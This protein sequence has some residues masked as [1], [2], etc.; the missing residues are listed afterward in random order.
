MTPARFLL[1][2]AYDW[3][4]DYNVGIWQAHLKIHDHIIRLEWIIRMKCYLHV[5]LV[6]DDP[7][8][9]AVTLAGET[10]TRVGLVVA[11]TH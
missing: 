6:S 3:Q 1:N 5:T 2:Q 11:V 4:E 9:L 8:G 10:V 7:L